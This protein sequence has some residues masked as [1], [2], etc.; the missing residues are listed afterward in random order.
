MLDEDELPR[1]INIGKFFDDSFD[2]LVQTYNDEI[3]KT[4]LRQ[5]TPPFPNFIAQTRKGRTF[6]VREFEHTI[7]SIDYKLRYAA[8]SLENL[9]SL[10]QGKLDDIRKTG[11]PYAGGDS[12][13]EDLIFHSDVF[14]SFIHGALEYSSW[15]FWFVFDTGLTPKQ[16]TLKQVARELM[17]KKTGI[18][19]FRFLENEFCRTG[20]ISELESYRDYVTHF[21]AL[22]PNFQVSFRQGITRTRIFLL[23][24]DPTIKPS[25]Y[26][27]EI[28]LVPYC[29]KTL[30]R[31]IALITEIY[32]V[33]AFEI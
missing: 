13:S 27:R 2:Y 32:R 19:L 29:N 26:K 20:W 18:P 16:V 17:K 22:E 9:L 6:D 24:D 21:G 10:Y 11:N 28:E 31:C 23:P 25:T 5:I 33:I 30:A 8:V 15:L 1:K 12:V 14:M 3:G 4:R 7:Q